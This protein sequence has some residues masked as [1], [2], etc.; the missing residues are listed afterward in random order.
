M[1]VQTAQLWF[2][3]KEL[4]RGKKL[5]DFVGPNEKTKVVVKLHKRGAGKPAREPVM[6]EDDRKQMMLHAFRRQEEL[7]VS[8][9]EKSV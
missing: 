7:K 8:A 4:L 2:S 5:R 9:V 3:G 6:S 1:D